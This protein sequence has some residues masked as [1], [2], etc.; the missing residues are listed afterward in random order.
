MDLKKFTDNVDIQKKFEKMLG[1]NTQH[2]LTSV[3]QVVNQSRYLQKCDPRTVINAAAT[4]AALR[5]PINPNLG[6]A[7]IIP[8]RDQAQFQIGYKGFIQLAHRTGQYKRINAFKI[9]QNQFI[10]WNPITETLETDFTKQ[11]SQEI[12]GYGAYFKVNQFE[13]LTWWS[14]NEVKQHAG[15]YSRSYVENKGVWVD[16]QEGFDAMAL[17]TVLK[18]ALVK[19][20]Y[21]TISSELQTAIL[22]DQ[23]IQTEEGVYEYPDNPSRGI[24]LQQI[25]SDKQR[26]RIE[27]QIKNAKAIGDLLKV[28]K[29]VKEHD[30]I[31]PYA[32]KWIELA[33]DWDTLK[34]VEPQVEPLGLE[35]EWHKKIDEFESAEH[36]F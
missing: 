22:A 14:L 13:K 1:D 18:N 9:P 15:K 32:Q 35:E 27:D 25:D 3:L 19:Y 16:G 28:N 31:K 29:H 30:M 4:A 17:K 11:P 6:F 26:K 33:Q 5:L 36:G 23:S 20:G 10:S 8:Y 2:F 12:A 34:K 7:Y 24:D 21:L